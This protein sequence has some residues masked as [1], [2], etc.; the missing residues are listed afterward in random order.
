[1]RRHRI[2]GFVVVLNVQRRDQSR[3]LFL[4][5]NESRI[6]AGINT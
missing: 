2:E 5:L 3:K 4:K 1:M 6:H